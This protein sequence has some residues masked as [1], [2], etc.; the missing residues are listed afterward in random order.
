MTTEKKSERKTNLILIIALSAAALLIGAGV[1]SARGHGMGMRG[2]GMGM[3]GGG[4]RLE[5]LK[6][7]LGLSDA[8][9]EQIKAIHAAQRTQAKPYLD[10]ILPLRQQMKA[11]LQ[12]EVVDQGQVIGIHGKLQAL[13][14]QL[15]AQRF[16]TRLKVMQVLTKEQRAKMMERSFRG[17]GKWGHRGKANGGQGKG[18]AGRGWGQGPNQGGFGGPDTETD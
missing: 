18:R 15:A 2:G 8:Q 4:Q 3:R 5:M 6:A 1:A 10:Q 9:L 17:K 13:Q 7:R 16:Q 14:Q 12:A 11:L